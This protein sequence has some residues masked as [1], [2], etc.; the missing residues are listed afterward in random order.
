MNHFSYIIR[1]FRISPCAALVTAPFSEEI[2]IKIQEYLT[3]GQKLLAELI[4]IREI[5]RIN[6]MLDLEDKVILPVC[7][8]VR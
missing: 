6:A 2:E 7:N 3:N 1:S 8:I 5:V 4:S